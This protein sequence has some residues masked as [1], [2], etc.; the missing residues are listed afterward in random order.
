VKAAALCA[1]LL[2]AVAAPGCGRGASE[3]V[4]E[5]SVAAAAD[6]RYAFEELAPRFEARCGCRL[7]LTFGSSGMLAA[8]IEQGFPADVFFSADVGY[9]DRL[10]R[11]GLGQPDSVTVY[12]L[13]RIV[14]ATPAR[15]GNRLGRLEE[16]ASAGIRAVAIPNPEHA[17]YGVA[18]RQALQAAG[19]WEALQTKLVLAENAAQAVQFVESGD[20]DAGIVPLSLAIARG[21]ALSYV[22]ID[23]ALYVP[24][25]QAAVVLLSS[26]RAE[27]AAEF[28]AYTVSDAGRA[29]L[30]RYGFEVP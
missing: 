8:Q 23:D 5:L 18:A 28:I 24:L 3:P 1:L 4:P 19:L 10:V 14:L 29:V 9:V 27:L 30:E 25:R 16:L 20:A 15:A 17:P 12:A 2:L 6:L 21:S 22:R 13:G 26:P 11:E 7:R